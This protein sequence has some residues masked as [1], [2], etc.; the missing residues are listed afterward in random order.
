MHYNAQQA[1]AAG[2]TGLTTE[3]TQS[4]LQ[5]EGPG[6]PVAGRWCRVRCALRVQHELVAAVVLLPQLVVTSALMHSR[7]TL[8]RPP[9]CDWHRDRKL[10]FELQ[11]TVPELSK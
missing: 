4:R 8:D 3:L 9:T 7:V 11:L 10:D 2:L 1:F 5:T 6:D